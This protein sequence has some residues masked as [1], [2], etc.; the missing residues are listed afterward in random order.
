MQVKI[1]FTGSDIIMQRIGGPD[2]MLVAEVYFRVTFA[3]GQV[4]KPDVTA[5]E[6][7]VD[8]AV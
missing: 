2:E 1:D 8:G 6:R 3:D 5:P 7:D 4:F